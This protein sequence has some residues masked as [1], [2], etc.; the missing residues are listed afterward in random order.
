MV[1]LYSLCFSEYLCGTA[2]LGALSIKTMMVSDRE[3][4][5]AVQHHHLCKPAQLAGRQ[6]LL[7]R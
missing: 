3:F 5:L 4:A 7:M 2:L 6:F 1:L